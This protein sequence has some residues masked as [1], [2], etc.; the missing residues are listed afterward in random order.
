MIGAQAV[1]EKERETAVDDIDNLK[2]DYT[3]IF[4]MKEV[5]E[6]LGEKE[7]ILRSLAHQSLVK[8]EQD[9]TG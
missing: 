2:K 8:L 6:V 7:C 3:K 4:G 5:H 9:Q 1:R